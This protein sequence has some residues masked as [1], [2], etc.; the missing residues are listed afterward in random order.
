M[1]ATIFFFVLT[2]VVVGCA[3]R[4]LLS[5]GAL[6]VV[7]AT[8]TLGLKGNLVLRVVVSG[9]AVVRSSVADSSSSVV[10]STSEMG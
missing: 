6:S 7:V 9:V 2:C 8:G 4:V 1:L 10:A 3:R 5:V